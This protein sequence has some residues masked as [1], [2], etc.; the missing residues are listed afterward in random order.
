MAKTINPFVTQIIYRKDGEEII[1]GYI[2]EFRGQGVTKRYRKADPNYMYKDFMH[3]YKASMDG[4]KWTRG[5][6]TYSGAIRKLLKTHKKDVVWSM[7]HI[8]PIPET[9]K[10]QWK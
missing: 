5:W 10:K 8:M 1:L 6:D 7:Y 9:F 4:K 2:G 3:S